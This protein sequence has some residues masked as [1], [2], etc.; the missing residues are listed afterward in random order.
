MKATE[1]RIPPMIKILLVMEGK[2]TAVSY[3]RQ[4]VP[5]EY[6]CR[7]DSTFTC[8]KLL[9]EVDKTTGVMYLAELDRLTDDELKQFQIVSFLRTVSLKGSPVSTKE[10]IERLHRLGCKVIFDIDDYW[11]LPKT[12]HY[13]QKNIDTESTENTLDA[14]TYADWVTTTTV[15][16]A[17]LISPLNA[18]VTVLPNCIDLD[19]SQFT[20]RNIPSERVR[21]GWIGG[22]FHKSDIE[23]IRN[24]FVL[25]GD[26]TRNKDIKDKYQ[27]CLGGFGANQEYID[28]E[29]F[30]TN[31]Y[32]N[33]SKDYVDY[34]QQTTP[35]AEHIS[36]NQPYRRLWGTDIWNYADLYNQID[37]ALAPLVDEPFNN[38][39]S[40]LKLIEAGMMKKAVIASDCL[41]YNTIIR[42]RENGLLV[43]PIRNMI[44]WYVAIRRLTKEK[45]MREDMAEQLH[46]DIKEKFNIAD[47]TLTR[48][49]LYKRLCE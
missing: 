33:L 35:L 20:I 38:C 32:K 27:L 40:E 30:F 28:I 49:Q 11:E 42:H 41:P 3:Y 36:Y 2:T 17:S 46:Q 6:L 29:K 12:H 47:H 26:W 43:K 39:K 4:I 9:G 34:L 31:N 45:N 25:L 14:I 10:K 21:F 22:I 48:A 19:D 44:D 8:C 13:Y 23:S 15:H 16:F 24:T 18:N 1:L 7:T 5:H 37:V